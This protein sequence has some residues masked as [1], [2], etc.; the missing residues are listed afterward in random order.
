MQKQAVETVKTPPPPG[1]KQREAKRKDVCLVEQKGSEDLQCSV[2]SLHFSNLIIYVFKIIQKPRQNTS[3]PAL[4]SQSADVETCNLTLTDPAHSAAKRVDLCSQPV[5]F[6]CCF[7]PAEAHLEGK[8]PDGTQLTLPSPQEGWQARGGCWYHTAQS[9]DPSGLSQSQAIILHCALAGVP[10][11][12]WSFV[13]LVL[14]FWEDT[15]L[16]LH[17]CHCVS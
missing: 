15:E 6:L 11:D 1:A 9:L 13:W 7:L 3:V 4:I 16:Q 5:V 14:I 2:L 10:F 8:W 12:P 17:E